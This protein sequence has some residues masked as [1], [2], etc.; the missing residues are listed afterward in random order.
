MTARSTGLRFYIS[1]LLLASS[2]K[3]VE[4]IEAITLAGVWLL[5]AKRCV[6]FH[7]DYDYDTKPFLIVRLLFECFRFLGRKKLSLSH[8]NFLSGLV[9]P[10]KVSPMN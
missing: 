8:H 5:N 1:I 4:G 3:N 2:S 9:V 6:H 10:V 7:L